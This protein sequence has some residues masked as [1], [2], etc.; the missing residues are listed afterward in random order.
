MRLSARQGAPCSYL[1]LYG[2]HIGQQSGAAAG[3]LVNRRL[4]G[5]GTEQNKAEKKNTISDL[6]D[7]ADSAQVI[8]DVYR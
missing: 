8:S 4:Q 1:V 7:N 2:N 6:L 5:K 3:N